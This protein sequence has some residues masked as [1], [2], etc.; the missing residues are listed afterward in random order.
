MQQRD[1]GGG[2]GEVF[3]YPTAENGKSNGNVVAEAAQ[4]QP[5]PQK[6]KGAQLS[7]LAVMGAPLCSK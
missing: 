1:G 2:D 3:Q 4:Q 6:H 5:Q 7:W